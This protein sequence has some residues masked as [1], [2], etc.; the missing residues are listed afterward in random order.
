[1]NHAEPKVLLERIEIMI[2]VQQ[3]MPLFQ[4]ERRDQAI[5][6]LAYGLTPATERPVVLRRRNGQI[7]PACFEYMK[8]GKV[9]PHLDK[10]GIIPNSL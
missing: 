5:D 7:D 3:P 1:M 2:A 9:L 4:A 6:G 10:S 8:L